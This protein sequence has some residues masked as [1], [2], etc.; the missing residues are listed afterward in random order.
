MRKARVQRV[1]NPL[2]GNLRLYLEKLLPLVLQLSAVK[3]QNE[4][5]MF[6]DCPKSGT[7]LLHFLVHAFALQNNYVTIQWKGGAS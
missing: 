5:G 3:L 2:P 7:T 1:I 4:K 6:P